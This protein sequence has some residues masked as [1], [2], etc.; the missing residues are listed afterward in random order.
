MSHLHGHD[1]P[2]QVV[3]CL[4]RVGHSGEIVE[5]GRPPVP[6]HHNDIQVLLLSQQMDYV[7][8]PDGRRAGGPVAVDDKGRRPGEVE[9]WLGGQVV[10]VELVATVEV[11]P[12]VEQQPD[13]Q[14]GADEAVGQVEVC[15]VVAVLA[16][17]ALLLTWSKT[18][19]PSPVASVSVR[20]PHRYLVLH[21]RS[22]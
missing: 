22:S 19:S 10:V 12:S 17:S 6:V 13:V 16:C 5:V 14:A 4:P 3:S 8:D 18:S 7:L 11:G 20:A 9:E 1:E 2:G 21:H 15:E